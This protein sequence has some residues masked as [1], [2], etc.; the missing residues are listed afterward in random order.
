MKKINKN[1]I[2]TVL[3]VS[4]VLGLTGPMAALAAT[5]PGLGAAATFSVLAQTAITGISTISGNVGL[6]S[7]GAGIT[8]LTAVNVAGTIY[9]TDGLAPSAAILPPSVQADASTAYTTNIPGQGSTGSIGPALDGLTLTTGVY[10]IGAGR[11]NGGVLHLNGPGIYIFRASSDFVSSGSISLE[12]GARACDVYWNVQTLATINGSSFAGTILAGTGVHFGANVTLDGRALAVG[13]DVTMINDTIS[14]PSCAPA[15]ATLRVIKLVVNGNGGTAVPSDFT[16][17]IKNAGV[18][19][20]GSPAAGTAAPGTSYSLSAGT[21]TVSENTNSSYVRTFTG[22]ACDSS[23]SV[24]LSPGDDKTCTIVNTDIPAPAPVAPAASSGGGGMMVPL[25][26]ILKVPSPLTLPAGPGSVTYSYTVWNVGGQQ[27]LTGV[28]VVDDKCSPVT[29][30]S[31]DTNSNNQLDPGENWKYSCTTTLSGT[32]TNTAI[33]TGHGGSQTAIATAVAT[34][35]VGAQIPL[36]LINIVKVPSRLTPF[37]FGGGDVTYTYTVTNPGVVAMSNVVVTDDKCGPVSGSSG[38]TNGNNL[39]DSGEIWT[40]TC[41]TNVTASTRNIATAEGK[42]NGFTALGYAF[43]NVLVSAAPGQV[44]GAATSSFP[45]T[46]LPPE[47]EST[48][49]DIVMLAGILMA[50]S[51]SLVVVLR[52]RTI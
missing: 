4:L 10:D 40:Y 20:S 43:A 15:P 7:I 27:A 5:D 46:G 42:A 16:V 22:T 44:L 30:L 29:L 12:N 50:A 26:G 17:H 9:S 6:N 47:G 41:R 2:V 18:D 48:P 3:A 33:A 25:I 19:V 52:K 28:T 51:I 49:W 23:G 32:T 8:G 31:G 39:L 38:D 14:G 1:S 24:T 13:G 11:L 21:Y 34:V 37:P 45:N 36:P 35:V